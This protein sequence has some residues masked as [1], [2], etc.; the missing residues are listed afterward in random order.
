MSNTPR[1]DQVL[2]NFRED[3]QIATPGGTIASTGTPITSGTPVADTNTEKPTEH[4]LDTIL[5]QIKGSPTKDV[6]AF[7]NYLKS[8]GWQDSDLTRLY[9]AGLTPAGI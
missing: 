7:S 9:L 1:F 2:K 3:I 8:K 6:T 4:E 5:G